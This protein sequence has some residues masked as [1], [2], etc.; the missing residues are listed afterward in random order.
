MSILLKSTP[1][2]LQGRLS[3]AFFAAAV[4]GN[5]L[6]DAETGVAAHIGGAEFAVWS[7]GLLCLLGTVVLAWRVPEL[8]RKATARA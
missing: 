2:H 3:G 5:R 4:S 6:G 8:W 1:D 7:G